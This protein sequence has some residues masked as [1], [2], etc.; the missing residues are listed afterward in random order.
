MEEIL[1]YLIFDW[2]AV[3]ATSTLLVLFFIQIYYYCAYYKK[4]Y[5]VSRLEDEPLLDEA[6]LPSVT[7]II[8]AKN[9]SENLEKNLPIVLN[10]NYPDFEVVVVNDGSTDESEAILK[11]YKRNYSHLYSTFAP[12]SYENESR[13]QKILALTI[14]IKAANKDVLLFTETDAHPANE[15]WIREMVS[16]LTPSKDIVLGYCQYESTGNFWSKIALFDHLIYS[17]QYISMA[18]KAQPF[19]G[20]SRNIAYRKRL[21]FDN[22]GFSAA[23]N[24]ENAEEVFL[25]KVMTPENTAITLSHN[26]F[27]ISNLESFAMWKFI[28]INYMRAKKHFNNF[29]PRRF[30]LETATRYLFYIATIGTAVYSIINLLWI[31]LIG[32]LLLLTIRTITQSIILSKASRLLNGEAYHFSI[33]ILEV[34]QPVYN[35]YFWK[36][37]KKKRKKIKTKRHSKK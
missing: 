15:N 10:Q 12:I 30:H 1:S 11:E 13:R 31:Y 6:E 17:L 25:N 4:P 8:I 27:M 33:P 16:R 14:G 23:L 22:K 5:S 7:I 32:T 35:T 3:I 29:S 37:S 9:D 36:Y 26:S 24:Y 19:G 20:D 18:L 21:F 28:K 2:T 34:W